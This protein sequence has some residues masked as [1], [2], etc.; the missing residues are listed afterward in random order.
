[1]LELI[2]SR[3]VSY[4][5]NF[6]FSYRKIVSKSNID[7]INNNADTSQ[8]SKQNLARIINCGKLLRTLI[9]NL[10]VERLVKLQANSL[11]YGNKLKINSFELNGQSATKSLNSITA[12]VCE[13]INDYNDSVGECISNILRRRKV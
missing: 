10:L 9:S 13:R 11:G 12:R 6:G 5:K 4:D 2:Q 8:I 1:M 7:L 3:K